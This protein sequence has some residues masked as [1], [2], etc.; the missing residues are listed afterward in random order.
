LDLNLT[1]DLTE[2]FVQNVTVTIQSN[3]SASWVELYITNPGMPTE[4]VDWEGLLNLAGYSE[5]PSAM[6]NV[7]KAF[8]EFMG[9]KN[10][11]QVSISVWPNWWFEG[12][13]SETEQMNVSFATSYFN[14]TDYKEVVQP[15]SLTLVSDNEHTFETAKEVATNQTVA[16]FISPDDLA[17]FFKVYLDQG[18]TF[19]VTVLRGD[20]NLSIIL[21]LYSS[22]DENNPLISSPALPGGSLIP[23]SISYS[24]E[25]TGW[26]YVEVEWWAGDGPYTMTL[27]ALAGGIS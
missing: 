9:E 5:G 19:N 20:I 16:G 22:T 26:Y 1:A 14:G 4:A 24:I 21:S 10:S 13:F 12:A 27:T 8:V 17:D 15:F 3:S 25:S 18:E 6:G 2:G 23:Q 11:H 7:E